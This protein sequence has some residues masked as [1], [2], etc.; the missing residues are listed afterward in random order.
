MQLKTW[1]QR[2][3][4]WTLAL[5]MLAG[6]VAGPAGTALAQDGRGEAWLGVVVE[7][8]NIGVVIREVEPDSPAA[9]A[10]LQVGD[11]ILTFDDREVASSRQLVRLVAAARPGQVVV[12]TV[13]RG[14]AEVSVRARLGHQP[15]VR[16]PPERPPIDGPPIIDIG[17]RLQLGVQYRSLT[18]EIAEAEG[19]SVNEG[20][21]VERV[22]PGT[23]A[24]DA[25]LQV[26]DIITAVDDDVVDIERTL[27][28]RLFAYEAQDRVIL[29]VVRDGEALE[30]GAVLAA[31]HPAK[32]FRWWEGL[33]PIQP[34]RIDIER[35]D[36]D[37]PDISIVPPDVEL[38]FA[39]DDLPD[40]EFGISTTPPRSIPDGQQAFE[41]QL[42]RGRTLYLVVPVEAPEWLPNCQPYTI[43]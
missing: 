1:L 39:F 7:D 26:G 15:G 38:P 29:T 16:V 28:D 31:D 20:A 14:D 13:Q 22:F 43:E 36:I 12:I 5:L 6:L 3:I 11:V 8:S 10:R 34:P 41:C 42:A 9:Q 24:E 18:P 25:G 27:S 35:P 19:L 37:V 17:G 21:L 30:I 33:P 23:P 4:G 32:R 2:G 40:L